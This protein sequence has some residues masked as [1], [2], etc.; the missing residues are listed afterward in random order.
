MQWFLLYYSIYKKKIQT[1]KL[2]KMLQI[3]VIIKIMI[4]I[5]KTIFNLN[6]QNGQLEILN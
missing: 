5:H 3:T 6:N 2:E 1:L 4:Y